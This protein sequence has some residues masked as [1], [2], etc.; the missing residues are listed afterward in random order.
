MVQG[1][2]EKMGKLK[3]LKGL[4]DKGN[5]ASVTVHIPVGN[6]VSSESLENILT[7]IAEEEIL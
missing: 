5:P 6:I 7:K 2:V 1:F 4:P 3:D